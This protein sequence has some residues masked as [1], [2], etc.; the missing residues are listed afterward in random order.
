[1]VMTRMKKKKAKKIIKK[2]M[3]AR[4][5]YVKSRSYDTMKTFAGCMICFLLGVGL[6]SIL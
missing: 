2:E 5:L 3:K 6:G 1:M 4:N